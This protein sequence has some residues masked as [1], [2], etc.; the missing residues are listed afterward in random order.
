MFLAH[1]VEANESV[2]S[3]TPK[4]RNA[5]LAGIKRQGYSADSHRLG[6]DI[7]SLVVPILSVSK[8]IVGCLCFVGPEFR[9]T[10]EKDNGTLLTHLIAAGN[11]VLVRLGYPGY[12]LSL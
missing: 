2:D 4:A 10:D 7:C 1:E 3:C 12:K 6:D 11:A 5:H 9:F 8:L